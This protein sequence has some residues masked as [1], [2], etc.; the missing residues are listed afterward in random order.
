MRREII[1]SRPIIEAGTSVG[2]VRDVRSVIARPWQTEAMFLEIVEG[3]K[4]VVQR[5][6]F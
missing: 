4:G 1:P 5:P 2:W 3:F 6:A